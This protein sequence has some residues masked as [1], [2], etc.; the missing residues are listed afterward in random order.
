MK[1]K[2]TE[3]LMQSARETAR[4]LDSKASS[5][6]VQGAAGVYISRKGAV[7]PSGHTRMFD[8]KCEEGEFT[9]Y[10]KTR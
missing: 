10:I 4:K 5:G 1:M 6:E 2:V 3:T 8:F 9:A 7:L